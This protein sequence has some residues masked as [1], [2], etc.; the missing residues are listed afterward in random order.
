MSHLR[1]LDDVMILGKGSQW[2]PR[3]ATEWF[4]EDPGG[5]GFRQFMPGMVKPPSP[6]EWA[7]LAGAVSTCCPAAGAAVGAKLAP[8]DARGERL[9]GMILIALEGNSSPLETAFH[10]CMHEVW[11]LLDVFNEQGDL[12]DHGAAVAA[13]LTA[14]GLDASMLAPGEEAA[15]WTFGQWAAGF[16]DIVRPPE[17]VLDL[18]AAIKSGAIAERGA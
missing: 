7:W 2:Q 5:A 6:E 1:L 10:E 12:E 14:Q 11:D 15:A 3:P 9:P 13:S 17:E 18:W 8:K 4:H 16:P